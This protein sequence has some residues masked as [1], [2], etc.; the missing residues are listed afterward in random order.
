MNSMIHILFICIFVPLLL[1]VPLVEKNSRDIMIY[2]LLGISAALYI[3]KVNGIMLKVFDDDI[4]FVTTT[5]TPITEEIIKALPVVLYAFM[6]SRSR[7]KLLSVSFALG[8]GFALFE[9]TYIL[10]NNIENVDITWAFIRGFSS[11]LMHGICTVAIGYG[12]SYVRLRR[13]LSVTG[14]F[15]LLITAII[16]HGI[17]NMLVQDEGLKYYGFLLPILTYIPFLIALYVT[18]R[19][20]KSI[21][22]PERLA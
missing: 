1:S 3:S 20:Q 14:T 12:L 15:A 9:N 7:Q 21:Q 11:A 4:L 18:H 13:K 10:I 2:I 5:I 16:Y 17:F 8:V 6:F 19:K 22:H